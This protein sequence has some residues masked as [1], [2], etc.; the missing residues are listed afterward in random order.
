LVQLNPRSVSVSAIASG[1]Y[2]EYL[3]S[4]AKDVRSY[5]QNVILSF[6]HEMNGGW[7]SWGYGHTSPAI[8]VAAWRHIVTVFRR[9]GAHNVTW[10]WTVNV[11]DKRRNQIPNPTAWWP[12]SSY[13][14]WVGI[15]GYFRRPSS[16]FAGVFGPTIVAVRQLTRDPILIAETG[17]PPDSRQPAKIASLFA[18]VHSYDLLGFVWFDVIGKSDFRIISPAAITAFQRA[19]KTYGA[20]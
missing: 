9:A 8:F 7:Y 13:V 11:I 18:G 17:A 3:A 16:Q 20:R 19:A 10:L 1:Q 5:G 6:G 12:G 2:D 14:D 15:D 4:Y